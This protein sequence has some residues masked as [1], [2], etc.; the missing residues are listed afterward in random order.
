MLFLGFII[1][2]KKQIIKKNYIANLQDLLGMIKSKILKV[3]AQMPIYLLNENTLEIL[4]IYFFFKIF[5]KADKKAIDSIEN[6]LIHQNPNFDKNI[7]YEKIEKSYFLD[8]I[9]FLENNYK[10]SDIMNKKV[11]I[12]IQ[13]IK[14]DLEKYTVNKNDNSFNESSENEGSFGEESNEEID[15]V[16]EENENIIMIP[17][18]KEAS[19]ATFPLDENN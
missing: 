11:D 10:S 15:D 8:S 19:T 16:E 6:A 17:N 5:K 14:I 18:N 7:Y 13:N 1:G 3:N 12:M 9:F 4:N 2:G